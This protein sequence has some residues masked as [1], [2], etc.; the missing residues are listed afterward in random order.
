MRVWISRLRNL[1]PIATLERCLEEMLDAGEYTPLLK[2]PNR[3]ASRH[4][5]W[6]PTTGDGD[7]V[8]AIEEMVS[9]GEP[10]S[11]TEYV[12]SDDEADFAEDHKY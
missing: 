11:T 3:S 10:P 5:A 9:D 6:V 12:S 2:K 7:V 8:A 1:T 4:E